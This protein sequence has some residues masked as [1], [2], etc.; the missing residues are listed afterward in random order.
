M[1]IQKDIFSWLDHVRSSP[2]Q[3][4]KDVATF[5]SVVFGYYQALKVKLIAEP[6]PSMAKH[7]R[8]WLLE[9]TNIEHLNCGWGTAIDLATGSPNQ[10]FEF[11]FELVDEYKQLVPKL[12]A[13]ADLLPHN[14]PTGQRIQL[15]LKGNNNRV[16]KP[17]RIDIVRYMP[18]LLHHLRFHYDDR[19]EDM[20]FLQH[21]DGSR[22]TSIE[23]AM[24]W[25][26]DEF[27]LA[28]SR[29]RILS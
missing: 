15:V 28:P 10:A 18:S 16:E 24:K 6:N 3:Y 2:Y 19:I 17:N 27:T 20:S 23:F 1:R 5:E 21:S 8:D 12:L 7:F 9:T 26:E 14:T 29:W 22:Q 11:F 25:V 13:T 4:G